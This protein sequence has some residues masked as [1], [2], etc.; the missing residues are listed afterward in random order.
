MPSISITC[1]PHLA[2]RVIADDTLDAHGRH[3][4]DVYVDARPEE[5]EVERAS[6]LHNKFDP[7]GT[8]KDD[9]V[10]DGERTA[11]SHRRFF[12]PVCGDHVDSFGC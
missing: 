11:I 7:T 12:V 5:K 1:A 2:G 4:L 6:G 3:V 8:S 10:C 9:S